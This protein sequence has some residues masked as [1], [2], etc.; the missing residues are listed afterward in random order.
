[1]TCGMLVGLSDEAEGES[2]VFS[3]LNYTATTEALPSL[4][5]PRTCDHEIDQQ[6]VLL[7]S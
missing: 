2:Q 3:D 7:K 6:T 5:A 4:L 1:M